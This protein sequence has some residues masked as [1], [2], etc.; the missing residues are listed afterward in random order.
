MLY[1]CTY[2]IFAKSKNFRVFVEN[3]FSLKAKFSHFGGQFSRKMKMIFVRIFAKISRTFF[4]SQLY[5]V[6]THNVHMH[7]PWKQHSSCTHATLTCITDATDAT[8]ASMLQACQRHTL[9]A[10]CMQTTCHTCMHACHT[11]TKYIASTLISC[12]QCKYVPTL[13]ARTLYPH[14]QATCCYMFSACNTHEITFMHV[15]INAAGTQ[16]NYMH[17]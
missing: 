3:P 4:S 15:H 9:C 6:C 13:H 10:Y 11:H 2:F 1:C 16:A 12:M 14:K 5:T 8:C 17:N 7:A